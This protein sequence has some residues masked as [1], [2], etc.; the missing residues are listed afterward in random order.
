MDLLNNQFPMNDLINEVKII[1]E[2]PNK[3]VVIFHQ[4]ELLKYVHENV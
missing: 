1:I 4:L 3:Y 2:T